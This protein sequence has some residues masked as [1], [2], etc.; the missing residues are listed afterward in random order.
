MCEI[1]SIGMFVNLLFIILK[2]KNWNN[3]YEEC[4]FFK[5]EKLMQK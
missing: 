4:I 2:F 1:K 3:R 5:M